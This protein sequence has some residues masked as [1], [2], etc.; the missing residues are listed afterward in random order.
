MGLSGNFSSLSVKKRTEVHWV[1]P[2]RGQTEKKDE[3]SLLPAR[4]CTDLRRGGKMGPL[5]QKKRLT[6]RK[7]KEGGCG[8][9]FDRGDMKVVSSLVLQMGLG[10][11]LGGNSG[12][13]FEVFV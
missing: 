3:M 11:G 7:I 10:G 9:F 13:D 12:S 5:V 4:I 8:E 6:S 1:A 2:S